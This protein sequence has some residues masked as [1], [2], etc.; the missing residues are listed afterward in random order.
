MADKLRWGVLGNALIARKCV[1]PAIGAS[2][3]G[4][5][6]GLATSLPGAA[7]ALVEEHGIVRLTENY[8]DLLDD[9]AIDAIY[10]PL[11]NHLHEL[12]VIRALNAGKHVLCEKPLACSAAEAVTMAEAASRNGRLLMEAQMY[13]FHPRT[14]RIEEMVAEGAIGVPRLVRAAFCFSMSEDLLAA[15]SNYRLNSVR[16]GGAL[17][18]VGCYGVGVAR[19]F[20]KQRVSRVQALALERNG[21]GVDL[22]LVGNLD[23]DGS[24]LASIEASFCSG[25]QQTYSVIGSGGVVEVPQDGFI[26]WDNDALIFHRVGDS[27][28]AE[29]IVIEGTDQYRLM[30]EHFGDRVADGAAPLVS[31]EDS[32]QNLAVLDALAESARCG[33]SIDVKEP[34]GDWHAE[35]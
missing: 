27:D 24:A 30:V 9:P 6:H 13:R 15:G 16:G 3:N 26:P 20:L 35:P 28:S 19:L 22:H 7:E 1:M 11:P 5:V 31:L 8:D 33:T 12:W 29:P 21:S 25:L 14:Q 23:F 18:D 2:K 10:V 34:L 17:F 32:I 4:V